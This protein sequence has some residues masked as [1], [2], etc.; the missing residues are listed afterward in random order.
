M[1]E[2]TTTIDP[3]YGVPDAVATD[4]ETTRQ[5]L[6]TAQVFWLSTVRAD[7]RPHVT[8]VVAVWLDEALHILTG[9]ARQ[10]ALNL[11]TSPHVALTTGCNDWE[12]GLD[13]VVEGDAVRVTDQEQLERLARAWA[14]RWDGRYQFVARD[15]G[16]FLPDGQ[17][18]LLVYAIT[19]ARVFAFTR[20]PSG[21]HTRHQF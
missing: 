1:H 2:P 14:T 10:K 4:W 9:E 16:F 18:I 15:G 5:A 13:V 3:R 19:P 12:H 7:G 11:R 20:G 17:D 8:P 21:G 6:E